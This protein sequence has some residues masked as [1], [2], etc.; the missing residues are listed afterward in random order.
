MED[1]IIT[2]ACIFMALWAWYFITGTVAFIRMRRELDMAHAVRV[3]LI[4]LRQPYE[5]I[6]YPSA[7][8]MEALT[9]R[10]FFL[11]PFDDLLPVQFGKYQERP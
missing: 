7:A 3:K 1:A 11:R 5:H 4:D 9:W 8:K 6:E 10:L 2:F